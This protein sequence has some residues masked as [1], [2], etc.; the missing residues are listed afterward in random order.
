M[1][2]TATTGPVSTCA[3]PSTSCEGRCRRR[4]RSSR[5]SR[6]TRRTSRRTRRART[7]RCSPCPS[8]A[9][10]LRTTS[11]TCTGCRGSS[12][13]SRASTL[14]SARQSTISIVSASGHCRRSIA[15]WPALVHTLRVSGQLD[16][17]YI[18]FTSDNGFHLGQHRLPAGKQT[19][20]DT[21]IH[22]PLLIRGPGITA[23]THVAQL[24]GNVDLA[25]T[26]EAM[27][28]V[29]APTFTD[30]RSLLGLGPRLSSRRQPL[31]HRLSRRAP[32]RRRNA[33][34][35][36]RRDGGSL[37]L[38]PA[39]PDQGGRRHPRPWPRS[40][41]HLRE[42]RDEPVLERHEPIPNYDAVR[43]QRYLY[44]AYANGDRELYDTE[45]RPGRDPQPRRQD[46]DPPARAWRGRVASLRDCRAQWVPH[47][48]GGADP[49]GDPVRALLRCPA[50]GEPEPPSSS[51]L[52]RRPFKAV[53]GI[54][55]PLGARDR[56]RSALVL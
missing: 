32:Q 19:A 41:G 7:R 43:T 17:T 4:R 22:V 20:Y 33:R 12:A 37:P 15:A 10:A 25:P 6:C 46:A 36:S 42:P 24:T 21:D 48:R 8:A 35:P 23:G 1:R 38:E 31:A 34:A 45:H 56:L 18:V 53:T 29:P 30:G 11:A 44:V 49:I 27:A 16:N 47:R 52:G 51:G 14:V 5:T 26:F 50:S 39:D 13:S 40:H 3:A 55:T 28:G 9:H 2:A 54:R